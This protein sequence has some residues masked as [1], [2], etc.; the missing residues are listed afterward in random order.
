[1]EEALRRHGSALQIESP[2]QGD[3]AGVRAHF[4]LPATSQPEEWP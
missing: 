2:I 1:V 3:A 4:L